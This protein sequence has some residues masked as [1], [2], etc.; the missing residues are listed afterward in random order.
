LVELDS[1][2]ASSF[3]AFE[4]TVSS[5]PEITGCWALGGGYDYLMRVVTRDIDAYQRLI[6][7][8]LERRAG[9]ARYLSYIVTKE[10]RDLPPAIKAKFAT[11]GQ[12]CLG[13]NRFLVERPAC[14]AFCAA[15]AERAGALTMGP[16]R[17]D[18]DLGPLMNAS[19]V[20]KQIAHVEDALSRGARL[21]TGGKVS[22]LGPNFFEPT[23]LA[24]VPP[25]AL[26]FR[27]ETFGP[28][29][30]IAPFDTEAEAVTRANDTEY[31]LVAYL[32]TED[33]RRIHRVSRALSF[34]MVAVNRTKVTGAPIPFG[35]MKQSGLGRE[36]ARFGLE[37]F[38]EI[39][40]VCRDWA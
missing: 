32:H 15:F 22:A 16:G 31:G 36:G 8:L 17:E 27:E 14:D 12:D 39:K 38:T 19:A 37:A 21:L 6:D 29:A 18:C 11:T 30:A 25:D 4:R 24:D 3:Q 10:I 23:V 28:V 40:Y 1:H 5:V 26:I 7:D 2:R 20:K 9:I 35:G 33:P 13:A 34:G